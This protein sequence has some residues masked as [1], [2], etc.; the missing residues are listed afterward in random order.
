MQMWV[1]D[2]RVFNFSRLDA[3]RTNFLYINHHYLGKD[4]DINCPGKSF[5]LKFSVSGCPTYGLYRIIA[6]KAEYYELCFT[7][8]A[9]DQ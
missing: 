8:V 2:F 4:Y 1:L 3:T 5:G 7:Q 6:S 9:F